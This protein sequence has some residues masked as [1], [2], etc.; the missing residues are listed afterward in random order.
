MLAGLFSPTQSV[1][2]PILSAELGGERVDLQSL[3]SKN[4]AVCEL[5]ARSNNIKAKSVHSVNR[6]GFSIYCGSSLVFLW[7]HIIVKH[8]NET[9]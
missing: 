3:V 5:K 8:E 2:E 7:N 9:C 1:Y 4:V 6:H